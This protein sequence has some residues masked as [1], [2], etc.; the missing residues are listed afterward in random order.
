MK[1]TRLLILLSIW[2]CSSLNATNFY[3]S[4]TGDDNNSG[5][6]ALP[7]RT[8]AKAIS[9]MSSG[10]NCY[11]TPGL[12]SETLN[13]DSLSGTDT[14]PITFTSSTGNQDDVIITSLEPIINT[15]VEIEPNIWRATVTTGKPILEP[16]SNR[17]HAGKDITD[18]V[19]ASL[20]FKDDQPLNM[21]RWPNKSI[22]NTDLMDYA[23][24][25]ID[26]SKS[27][28]GGGS[29]SSPRHIGA[30]T[31]NYYSCYTK[32]VDSLPA[33]YNK[34]SLAD[35]YLWGVCW[36]KWV[37]WTFP[38][39]DVVTADGTDADN[40]QSI[41][42]DAIKVKFNSNWI[43]LNMTP[44]NNALHGSNEAYLVGSR[45]MLD[46][47]GEFHYTIDKNNRD[48]SYIE[49]YS[50]TDPNTDGST[51]YYKSRNYGINMVNSEYIN[52]SNLTLRAAG[53]K[54][55]NSESC[56]FDALKIEIPSYG[57][58]YCQSTLDTIIPGIRGGVEI[59]ASC[60][61]VVFK[62]SDIQDCAG[63][64]VL[65]NGE[66]NV[67]HNNNIYNVSYLGANENGVAA[68]GK[69]QTISHN[70]VSRAGR[71][72]ISISGI[73]Q[74]R[75][76]YNDFSNAGII[77]HDMGGLHSNKDVSNTEIA[78]NWVHDI[79]AGNG[80]YMD[81][82]NLNFIVHHNVVWDV[83]GTAI[84]TNVPSNHTMIIN[85]T[86][87]ETRKFSGTGYINTY[88]TGNYNGRVGNS[89][90]PWD[91]PSDSYGSI[92]ANNLAIEIKKS[93]GNS[94]GL[95]DWSNIAYGVNTRI[96]GN[97]TT[98]NFDPTQQTTQYMESKLGGV[99]DAGVYFK[100]LTEN[101]TGDRPDIGAYE[102]DGEIWTAGHNFTTKPAIP[103]Y[104]NPSFIFSNLIADSSF[105]A[106]KSGRA[107]GTAPNQTLNGSSE[108]TA[109]WSINGPGFVE[110]RYFSGFAGAESTTSPA[111]RNCIHDESLLIS[112]DSATPL[113]AIYTGVD[114]TGSLNN[115]IS[116]EA[117]KKY[118]FNAFVRNTPDVTPA[119]QDYHDLNQP[120]IDRPVEQDGATDAMSVPVGNI[121]LIVT[122]ENDTLIAS[123]TLTG[124]T[125]VGNWRHQYL[126]FTAPV[127]GLVKVGFEKTAAGNFYVENV[128]LTRK[129]S[130]APIVAINSA[131]QVSKNN[132]V[133]L[134][135]NLTELD[136]DSTTYLWDID[137][138]QYT[139]QNPVHTF[140]ENGTK[141]A[142]LIAVDEHGVESPIATKDITVLNSAPMVFELGTVV[143]LPVPTAIISITN[144]NSSADI[145]LYVDTVDHGTTTDGWAHTFS[146]SGVTDFTPPIAVAMETELLDDV[147]YS[148]R[149]KVIGSSD[150]QWSDVGTFKLDRINAVPYGDKLLVHLSASDRR[151]TSDTSLS[152][153]QGLS[154]TEINAVAT[155]TAP[156]V[157]G[158][159]S[160]K[161]K[162]M[163]SVRFYDTPMTIDTG[164]TT[165]GEVASF[166][167]VRIQAM[168]SS[169]NNFQR[170]ISAAGTTNDYQNG[171]W[172]R[173]KNHIT[174]G[175][176]VAVLKVVNGASYNL[177]TIHLGRNSLAEGQ[178]LYGE[179][180]EVAIYNHQLDSADATAV[181]NWLTAKWQTVDSFPEPTADWDG[182]GF[183]N[184]QE[185]VNG[186]DP[187]I[188]NFDT[189][190]DGASDQEEILAGT[191]P[192]NF[193]DRPNFEDSD[194]DGLSDA[195]ETLLNSDPLKQDS[196]E[197]GFM[198]KIEFQAKTQLDKP[199]SS[200]TLGNQI[201]GNGSYGFEEFDGSEFITQSGRVDGTPQQSATSSDN[202]EWIFENN[203]HISNTREVGAGNGTN[204][205]VLG[206]VSDLATAG[207]TE[208]EGSVIIKPNINN[209]FGTL[210]FVTNSWKT[211][212][213]KS[214]YKVRVEYFD[215]STKV[216]VPLTS[217]IITDNDGGGQESR[218]INVNKNFQEADA[219]RLTAFEVK[220][221]AA[222]NFTTGLFIDDVALTSYTQNIQEPEPTPVLGLEFEKIDKMLQWSCDDEVSVK[223]YQIINASTGE[224]IAIITAD[225]SNFYQFILDNNIDV[226]LKVVDYSGYDQSFIPNNGK[227]TS[228][229]YSLQK[230]WNLLSIPGDKADLSSLKKATTGQFWIWNG[231]SY[232]TSITPVTCQGFWVF[233][234]S[235]Q[236]VVI[237]VEK[238]EIE[239]SLEQGWNLV[240][241]V[242]NCYLPDSA[243][244]SYIWEKVY[245]EI[246][247]DE[248]LIQGIG[249][250][251]FSL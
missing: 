71:S 153:W 87:L 181:Q 104:Q 171:G 123:T 95:T 50:T 211:N 98:I 10:D 135:A 30:K 21:A 179:I 29:S 84:R 226:I 46:T 117:G 214:T 213:D 97:D 138:T 32:F 79:E 35:A 120:T 15:W 122:D 31:A 191:D 26:E 109:G 148:Y 28:V 246:L 204:V 70:T 73:S 42:T 25:Q 248:I 219:L 105:N 63:P 37:S 228:V 4:T 142:T 176:N 233:S 7:F 163:N 20:I 205:L 58:S 222:V 241:P 251:I 183:T 33:G 231:I 184:A 91:G 78:Y 194:L 207:L 55:D 159:A 236:N 6:E 175:N 126:D 209:G 108:L 239:M 140:T 244:I 145:E 81:N 149:F 112:S 166:V 230:G 88:S 197:D 110:A 49:I 130:R 165:T 139:V 201:I 76:I 83:K 215:N 190:K 141:T 23:G 68:L 1:F 5:S 85:N 69:R 96:L 101:F 45:I 249:Y 36:K 168:D 115:A 66:E 212:S 18:M 210:S 52:L 203:A 164:I 156:T 51:Y 235:A 178:Q 247:Q 19:Y 151:L 59:T 218:T 12:Y 195:L 229:V 77:T 162:G 90:G 224:V 216:W 208:T 92:W 102:K 170:F 64:A 196:D 27:T 189:D 75:I 86:L 2:T 242:E 121:S 11:I 41:Y 144:P 80:I 99:I 116:V 161:I 103:T 180:L 185:A 60:K 61:K 143:E 47:E 134:Q 221:Q 8:I 54:V 100:G 155:G 217:Q 119:S 172:Q 152:T 106:T 220:P 173:N 3:V 200:P 187:S 62:N 111:G 128:G 157:K 237:T 9:V 38:V 238:K 198:D 177:G 57:Y 193:F 94:T 113:K 72:A 93:S 182:D 22:S 188:A 232:E 89:Y 74:S 133:T 24:G 124:S 137:G 114:E 202:V 167:V 127:S 243:L 227:L 169:G 160:Y 186:T 65:M 206:Y 67:L 53:V 154:G 34:G 131:D 132:P 174:V 44:G 13:L 82:F 16:S 56:E 245:K 48:N 129:F 118:T 147:T 158:D 225:G 234:K 223:E 192:N 14:I 17:I 199:M 136:G 146:V 240:G 39:E 40:G 43:A 107:A 150:T 125:A 250:W